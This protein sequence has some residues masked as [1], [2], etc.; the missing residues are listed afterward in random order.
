MRIALKKEL[1][2]DPDIEVVGTAVDPYDAKDKIIE[3]DPDVITLD[4]EMPRMDGITF[5]KLIMERR[6]RPVIMLSSLSTPGSQKAMEALNAG[7]FEVYAKPSGDHT[8]AELAPLLLQSIKAANLRGFQHANDPQKSEKQTLSSASTRLPNPTKPWSIR[9]ML[10]LGASTGGTE[11][12]KSFFL[13]LPE[14]IPPTLVVQHIPPHFSTAFAERLNTLCPFEVKE[15]E[16]GDEVRVGRVLIAPGDYHMT[17]EYHVNRFQVRL[18]QE[19]KIW[20]QRP[21]VDV[22]FQSAAQLGIKSM[23]GAIFTGMGK[24]GAEGLLELR[25]LGCRTFNQDEKSSVVYGMPRAAWELGASEKQVPLERM[26]HTLLQA[27]G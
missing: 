26:G 15:A 7:A 14:H 9:Q 5:L 22:L 2:K 1:E 6:P 16:D 10:L 19:P 21:A 3:L 4:I 17:L 25:K 27:F 12:L 20:H 8:L 24:D 18:N 13:Q 11:A 23:V